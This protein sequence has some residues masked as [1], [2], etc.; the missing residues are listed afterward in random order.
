MNAKF[1]FE[2]APR[3]T[4]KLQKWDFQEDVDASFNIRKHVKVDKITP[5]DYSWKKFEE[6]AIKYQI[7]LKKEKMNTLTSRDRIEMNEIFDKLLAC[8]IH[9]FTKKENYHVQNCSAAVD[10]DDFDA[11]I[12][13][14]L[15]KC[16]QIGDKTYKEI[17]SSIDISNVDCFQLLNLLNCEVILTKP[18]KELLLDELL[19]RNSINPSY[20]TKDGLCYDRAKIEELNIILDDLAKETN[21]KIKMSKPSGFIP[22]GNNFANYCTNSINRELYKLYRTQLQ[23]HV[24][25]AV[26]MNE[27][28]ISTINILSA[29]EAEETLTA[30]AV[31]KLEHQQISGFV[32]QRGLDD[33]V[34]PAYNVEKRQIEKTIFDAIRSIPGGHIVLFRYGIEYRN[35]EY[36]PTNKKTVQQTAEH[37]KMKTGNINKITTSIFKEIKRRFPNM[38]TDYLSVDSSIPAY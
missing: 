13:M 33:V 29:K 5:D 28:N 22:R 37:F 15:F 19:K 18:P 35:G 11:T 2:N 24:P 36:Y 26:K 14:T 20:I 38:L 4:L 10:I 1:V 17:L 7:F 16:L 9:F 32:Q 23:V 25:A 30:S 3:S 8:M 12:A 27:V 31:S 6:N 21:L 34:A